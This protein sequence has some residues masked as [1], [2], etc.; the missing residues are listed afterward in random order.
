MLCAA[1]LV[2]LTHTQPAFDWDHAELIRNDGRLTLVS[3]EVVYGSDR[4]EP[5][6]PPVF[7]GRLEF[8]DPPSTRAP[9]ELVLTTLEGEERAK[10]NLDQWVDDLLNFP[11]ERIPDPL[12]NDLLYNHM[13]FTQ[14]MSYRGHAV[15]GDRVVVSFALTFG[16][17]GSGFRVSGSQ[18]ILTEITLVGNELQLRPIDYENSSYHHTAFQYPTLIKDEGELFY[19]NHSQRR[20]LLNLELEE[21]REFTGE[22]VGIL[23][24]RWLVSTDSARVY[25]SELSGN[26]DQVLSHAVPG[27]KY[28]YVPSSANFIY[29]QTSYRGELNILYP[30]GRTNILDLDEPDA[31]IRDVLL[32]RQPIEDGADTYKA[33]NAGDGIVLA[34]EIPYRND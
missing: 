18:L 16:H 17:A 9:R 20:I 24:E 21:V 32:L 3:G 7:G 34:D 11:N 28:V 15:V 1:L 4:S 10:I 13:R 5:P 23:R 25:I 14:L 30:D 29:Y 8:V 12:R 26:P 6:S 31:V 2:S 33:I 19:I 27:A 22:P